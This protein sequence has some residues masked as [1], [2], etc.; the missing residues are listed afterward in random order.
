MGTKQQIIHMAKSGTRP[1]TIARELRKPV[2][3]VYSVI[4][5][6]RRQGEAIPLFPTG[7]LDAPLG[8]E[9]RFNLPQDAAATLSQEAARRGITPSRL[10]RDL[11]TA[12]CDDN[13]F[14]AILED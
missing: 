14:T 7:R 8:Q 13:I 5:A 10:A 3:T 11:I 6:A 12:I 9:L 1:A 4:C 2:C